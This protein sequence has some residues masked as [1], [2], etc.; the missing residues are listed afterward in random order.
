[1]ILSLVAHLTLWLRGLQS[2]EQRI[3]DVYDGR[4]VVLFQA[5]DQ[6]GERGNLCTSSQVQEGHP[7]EVQ[8]GRLEAP[9][10]TDE[11]DYCA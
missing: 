9:V 1:M 8:D 11:Y 10:D 7:Q 6:A 4:I 2:N 5:S 3:R